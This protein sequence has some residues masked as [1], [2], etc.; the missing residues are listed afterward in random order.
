MN[1]RGDVV[2]IT[3][4]HPVGASERVFGRLGVIINVIEDDGETFY[5]VKDTT[6]ASFAYDK[7]ELRDAEYDEI[8]YAFVDMVKAI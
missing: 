3:C 1:I 4:E 5:D 7:T 6:G 8:V 2:V